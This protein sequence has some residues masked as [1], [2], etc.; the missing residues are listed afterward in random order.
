MN[1]VRICSMI[2]LNCKHFIKIVNN[3]QNI[4]DDIH[5]KLLACGR[6][7][8]RS[9]G[10]DFLTARKLSE[11]SGCSIG[12]IYNQFANMDEFVAEENEFTLKELLAYLSNAKLDSDGYQ[13]LMAGIKIFTDFVNDNRELWLLLY[14]F[15]LNHQMALSINYRRCI[16]N[17]RRFISR[18]FECLFPALKTKKR[19]IIRNVFELGLFSFGAMIT[20]A[21]LCKMKTEERDN[22]CM[23][24]AN[25]FLAGV[26]LLEE[27]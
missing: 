9:K 15:H 18:E 3:M 16:V 14:N 21:M 1:T 6:D 23:I 8:L 19:Q 26:T 25:A 20:S 2:R 7:L 4:K 13:N 17:L 27:K 5:E 22:L 12:M 24:F 11:A 10:M